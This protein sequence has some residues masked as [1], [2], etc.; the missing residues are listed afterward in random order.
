MSQDRN[1]LVNHLTGYASQLFNDMRDAYRSYSDWKRD[2]SRLCHELAQKGARILTLDM[3]ALGKHFDKCLSRGLYTPSKL[4]L[5]RA[6]RG[7]QVPVF[8]RGLFLQV[9]DIEGKLRSTPNTEVIFYLRT[10]LMGAKKLRLPFSDRSLQREIKA[11]TRI[12]QEIAEP[13]LAWAEDDLLGST[14]LGD[15]D[16]TPDLPGLESD[17][18]NQGLGSV[19]RLAISLLDKVDLSRAQYL[20]GDL[21]DVRIAPEPL[22]LKV[23]QQVA[24][25]VIAQFGDL[26]READSELPKHGPGAVAEGGRFTNKYAFPNWPRKLQALFPA[27]YYASPNL[28]VGLESDS[29]CGLGAHEAPSRLIAVPKTAKGPRLI[30]AEPAAHQ[31]IQQ[32]IKNQLESRLSKTPLRNCISFRDQSLSGAMA[33]AGSLDGSNA[34]IDLSSASDRLSCWLVERMFRSN[35]TLLLRLH[36]CRTRWL[37]YR[38]DD[39]R[40]EF[41]RLRK[42]APMGSAVTFPVQSIIYALLAIGVQLHAEGRPVSRRSI[43]KA[44]HQVRVFGDDI[45]VPVGIYPE[46]VKVLEWLGLRA[47]PDK[48]FGEGNFR[49]SCGVDAFGGTDVTPPYLLEPEPISDVGQLG[50]AVAVRNNFYRKGFWKT[51]YWL[52]SQMSRYDRFVPD[53]H[54]SRHTVGRASFLGD[55][56]SLCRSRWNDG[57]QRDEVQ[58]AIPKRKA[59]PGAMTATQRLF[60]WFIERPLPEIQWSSGWVQSQDVYTRP[61][62][63]SKDFISTNESSPQ[64]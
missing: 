19:S 8:L 43:E 40:S 53:I 41:I 7:E 57:L 52:D 2:H 64:T 47:N 32:L 24:D 22:V 42:F 54:A 48:T 27:D 16:F 46:V 5:G 4:Y 28:G 3:P 45:I 1:S 60:Q 6:K 15:L 37:T 17:Q 13:T 62:W 26:F 51:A 11:F 34:T 39:K 35:Q 58:V 55:N 29:E 23:C 50:S 14:G 49:E 33:L 61:G 20:F 10:L 44:S 36:A 25:I 63:V 30:A 12:E 38:T 21:D 9:F 31:W 56:L 18:P 59:T